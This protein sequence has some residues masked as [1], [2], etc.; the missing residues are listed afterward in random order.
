VLRL[1]S[2]DVGTNSTR[3]LIA[4]A[5][6]GRIVAEHA[7]ELVITR[8]GKGVDRTRKLDPA[9]LART[10]EVI[11]GYAAECE[12]LGV[13]AV[14]LAATSATRDATN[15]S[16]LVDG[17]RRILGVEPEVLSGAEEAAASFLG[18]TYDLDGD[19]LPQRVLVFDIG[20]G[21]TEL[22]VGRPEGA[23][24]PEGGAGAAGA[25]VPEV[26]SIDI[27]SVR[28]TERHVTH[29][30]LTA[31]E[32]KAVRADAEGAISAVA[33]LVA[34][35][36]GGERPHAVGVAGTVTTVT[37]IALGLERYERERVHRATLTAEMA[38]ATADRLCAMTVAEKAA[39]A[40][41]PP[42]RED[43]IAAGSLILDTILRVLDLA[44]IQVSETDILD[45]VLLGLARRLGA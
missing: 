7:R 25:T 11:E 16:E 22:M 35:G 34:P 37:A 13:E 14:R 43:V 12:R 44:E 1:A 41:M 29:D 33:G 26:H 40:V 4:D 45:G 15:A 3:L 17:V 20:G 18:A 19:A 9:A 6:D 21:S 32:I 28:L 5:V 24:G 36:A 39:I 8:L 2:M 27:G 10:L 31:D 38:R 30:P 42:G 23:A